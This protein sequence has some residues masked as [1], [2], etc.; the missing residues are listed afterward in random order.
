[1]QSFSPTLPH[2]SEF[3]VRERIPVFGNILILRKHLAKWLKTEEY[4]FES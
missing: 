1:M 2:Q 3:S 4:Q